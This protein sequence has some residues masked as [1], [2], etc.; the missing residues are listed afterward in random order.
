MYREQI[1]QR[2]LEIDQGRGDSTKLII[3]LAYKIKELA[4]LKEIDVYY[5]FQSNLMSF[6]DLY[7]RCLELAKDE[8]HS[9]TRGELSSFNKYLTFYNSLEDQKKIYSHTVAIRNPE[10][11]AAVQTVEVNFDGDDPD[12]KQLVEKVFSRLD[13]ES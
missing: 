8:H 6:I 4:S 5:A 12:N 9:P 10:E 11:G 13:E 3:E 1:H 7:Q 2:Y